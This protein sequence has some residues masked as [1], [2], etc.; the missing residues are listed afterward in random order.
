MPFLILLFL[1]ASEVYLPRGVEWVSLQHVSALA[2]TQRSIPAGCRQAQIIS[3]VYCQL[4]EQ[5]QQLRLRWAASENARKFS[6]VYDS[7]ASKF[8][9]R[10]CV[11]NKVGQVQC[12]APY[13]LGGADIIMCDVLPL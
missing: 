11:S 10:I 3:L 9:H 2:L 7:L 8:K 13:N 6:E 4:H 1:H 5:A 12:Y